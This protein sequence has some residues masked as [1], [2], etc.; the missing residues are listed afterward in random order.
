LARIF[1]A[2]NRCKGAALGA[3]WGGRQKLVLTLVVFRLTR[4]F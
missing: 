2:T 4:Q 1:S 3:A